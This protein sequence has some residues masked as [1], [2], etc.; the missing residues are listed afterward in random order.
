MALRQQRE[1]RHED[2][3]EGEGRYGGVD[4]ERA[5]APAY[6]RGRIRRALRCGVRVRHRSSLSYGE[7]RSEP[8]GRTGSVRRMSSEVAAPDPTLFDKVV[9]LCKRRGFVFPSAE[10]YGGFRSTYDY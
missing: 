3:D 4:E 6:H 1:E 5:D 2:Q 9:N 10:I 7:W 8:R